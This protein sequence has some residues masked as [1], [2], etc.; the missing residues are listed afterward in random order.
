MITSINGLSN[1]PIQETTTQKE[2]AIENVAKE[3]KQ[4]KNATEEKFDYSKNLF[5]PWSETIKEFIKAKSEIKN[6]PSKENILSFFQIIKNNDIDI[7]IIY[8]EL[9]NDGLK[10]FVSAF[11]DIMKSL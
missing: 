7:N 1:T 2:N 4:D 10:Q 9:L 11:D 6:V 8:K 5:K 3:G